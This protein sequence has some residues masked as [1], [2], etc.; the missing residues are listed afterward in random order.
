MGKTTWTAAD[1]REKRRQKGIPP[2]ADMP[3]ILPQSILDEGRELQ[4][5]MDMP[6]LDWPTSKY[7]KEWQR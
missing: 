1:W 7:A 5:M 4:A 3:T 6:A 2:K